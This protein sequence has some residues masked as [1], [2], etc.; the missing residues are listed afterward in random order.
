MWLLTDCIIQ[1]SLTESVISG[2]DHSLN[3]HSYNVTVVDSV[4]TQSNQN[5]AGRA[6]IE[7]MSVTVGFATSPSERRLG[8]AGVHAV[9]VF[10]VVDFNR[11][12]VS[13]GLELV[14][15]QQPRIRH[16]RSESQPTHAIGFPAKVSNIGNLSSFADTKAIGFS[17]KVSSLGNLSTFADIKAIGFSATR[18]TFANCLCS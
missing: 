12:V 2:D 13:A 17:V 16:G 6:N 14:V 3:N 1:R 9:S 8:P 5:R 18:A 15:Q 11:I 10:E 4:Q 7:V